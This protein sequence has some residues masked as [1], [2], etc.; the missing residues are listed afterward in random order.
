MNAELVGNNLLQPSEELLKQHYYD[1]RNKPFYSGLCKFM[2]SS[3]VLATVSKAAI[4][5]SLD[6]VRV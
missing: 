1:L 6:C 2:S 3:P 5:I 4:Y